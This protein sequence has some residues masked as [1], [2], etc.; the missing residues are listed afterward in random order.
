MLKVILCVSAAAWFPAQAGAQGAEFLARQK[1]E[2]QV[3]RLADPQRHDMLAL[4][5]ASLM[6]GLGLTLSASAE[7]KVIAPVFV[8][9]TGAVIELVDIRLLLTRIAIQSGAQDHA[10]LIRAQV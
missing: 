6:S 8:P 7:P 2:S 3:S 9:D 4:D 5:G 1:L 10:A